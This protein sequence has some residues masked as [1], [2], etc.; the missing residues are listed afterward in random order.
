MNNRQKNEPNGPKMAENGFVYAR[1]SQNHFSKSKSNSL[2]QRMIESL[3]ERLG[4]DS[5]H[6]NFTQVRF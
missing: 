2:T 6:S 1:F 5:S 3:R 4:N